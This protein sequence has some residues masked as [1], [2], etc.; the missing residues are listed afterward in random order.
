MRASQL[1]E[2]LKA[3][4]EEHGDLPVALYDWNEAYAP[5]AEATL[6]T[7]EDGQFCIDAE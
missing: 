5:P 3:L 2:Q 4:M 6:V 7:F 1:I